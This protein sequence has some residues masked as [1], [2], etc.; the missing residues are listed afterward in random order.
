M[1]TAPPLPHR[2]G[3]HIRPRAALTI[4]AIA[5]LSIAS[6]AAPAH[7]ESDEWIL[8]EGRVTVRAHRWAARCGALPAEGSRPPGA[9]YLRRGPTTLLPIDDAAPVFGPG[10]C[11][12]VMVAADPWE[13]AEGPDMHCGTADGSTG[14]LALRALGPDWLSVVHQLRLVS[15]ADCAAD[16]TAT[17]VLRRASAAPAPPTSPSAAPGSAAAL[18]PIAPPALPPDPVPVPAQRLMA[19]TVTAPPPEVDTVPPRRLP[20]FA[21]AGSLVLVGLLGLL[22][23]LRRG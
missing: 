12:A 1:P 21:L 9:R 22:R 2:I 16:V 14:R 19:V 7:A 3:P 4:L 11:R 15:E 13:E 10:V 6:L 8:T 17:F 23:S 18:A 5:A 20:L